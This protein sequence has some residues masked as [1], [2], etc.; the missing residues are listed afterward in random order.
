MTE[1]YWFIVGV[2]TVAGIGNAFVKNFGM[3]TF[4][5]GVALFMVLAKLLWAV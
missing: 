5:L 4:C 2:N 3:A 1:L